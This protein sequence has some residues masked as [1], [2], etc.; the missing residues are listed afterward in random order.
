[1]PD[2]ILWWILM[3]GFCGIILSLNGL[4]KELVRIRKA[5]ESSKAPSK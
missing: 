4:W 2:P 5:L 3:M 1:M